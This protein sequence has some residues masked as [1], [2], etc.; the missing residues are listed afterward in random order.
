MKVSG[1]LNELSTLLKTL[2]EKGHFE[3]SWIID[4]AGLVMAEEIPNGSNKE[5]L[6]AMFIR[7]ADT[8]L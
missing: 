5:E 6:I 1:K 8:G 7:I 2:N 4:S 3:A